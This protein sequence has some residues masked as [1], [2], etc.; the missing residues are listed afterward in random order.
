[1]V[2]ALAQLHEDVEQLHLGQPSH[3]V[4]H[5][6]VLQQNLGVPAEGIPER[7]CT[8]NYAAWCTYAAVLD[9]NRIFYSVT[10]L[11]CYSTELP[12]RV[13]LIHVHTS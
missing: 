10:S 7:N 11:T 6:N 4:H 5:I 3:T 9:R 2:A 13:G 1:M 8:M 12:L